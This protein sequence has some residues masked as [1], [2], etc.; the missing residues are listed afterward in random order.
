M[1]AFGG[2]RWR[3]AVGSMGSRRTDR[4]A[5]AMPAADPRIRSPL[6]DVS[7][8]GRGSQYQGLGRQSIFQSKDA[9][10]IDSRF[11]YKVIL[12]NEE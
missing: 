12:K 11:Q 7:V 3:L 10:E 2:H 8:T 1:Q 6:D 9:P 5:K 4:G